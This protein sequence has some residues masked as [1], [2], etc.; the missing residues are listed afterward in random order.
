MCVLNPL[1]PSL[2]RGA[3]GAAEKAAICPAGGGI[4]AG[5]SHPQAVAPGPRA[6]SP[7]GSVADAPYPCGARAPRG[8]RRPPVPPGP[9]AAPAPQPRGARSR[10]A[11]P[12]SPAPR[13]RPR[14]ARRVPGAPQRPGGTLSLQPEPGKRSGGEEEPGTPSGWSPRTGRRFSWAPLGRAAMAFGKSHRDPFATSV[15]HLIGKGARGQT[16]GQAVGGI[17]GPFLFDSLLRPAE[18]RVGPSWRKSFPTPC[19]FPGHSHPSRPLE[20]ISVRP[21]LSRTP[22][23]KVCAP[24]PPCMPSGE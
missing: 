15:G 5:V 6:R 22:S 18:D 3:R 8:G 21:T 13:P 19:G 17:G 12:G 7:P 9:A 24:F 11:A 16:P 10:C 1:F 14:A 2:Q 23:S 4:R 20:G